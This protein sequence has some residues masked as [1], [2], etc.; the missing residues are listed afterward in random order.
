MKYA[1]ALSLVLAVA[2]HPAAADPVTVKVVDVAGGAAYV[3][4]GRAAGLV[5]GTKIKLRGGEVTVVEVTEKTAMVRLEAVHAAIGDSGVADVTP[6]VAT[7][8]RTLDKPHPPKPR[9]NFKTVESTVGNCGGGHHANARL[10]L[11]SEMMAINSALSAGF[12]L[13]VGALASGAPQGDRG[14]WSAR[15]LSVSV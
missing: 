7:A 8:V 3:A 6:G 4:P 10:T 5:R 9:S 1:L 12:M 14:F 2:A 13:G 11:H 15:L